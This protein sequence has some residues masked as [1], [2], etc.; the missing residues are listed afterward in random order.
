VSPIVDLYGVIV[1][2]AAPY[3]DPP[4]LEADAMHFGVTVTS[5]LH[6]AWYVDD[7]RIEHPVARIFA[8]RDGRTNLP[9]AKNEK[10]GVQSRTSVFDLGIRHLLLERGEIYY[11]N[12]KN[13]LSADLHD[14]QLQSSFE[15][16]PKRYSGTLSYRDGH[17]QLQNGNPIGHNFSA[18]FVATPAEF[19]LETADLRTPSS[20]FSIVATVRDYSQPQVHATYEATVDSAEFRRALNNRSLPVGIILSSGVLDYGSQSNRAF[21]GTVTANGE[22]HSSGLTVSN[23]NARVQLRDIGAR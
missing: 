5:L 12:R 9:P 2:G 7:V 14:L 6:R 15:P 3:P 23:Q 11:N 21:L 4:L 22:V 1:H 8:D 10:P 19:K 18:R 13:E 20:R 17:L 16:A